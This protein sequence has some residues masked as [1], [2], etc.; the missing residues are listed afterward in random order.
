MTKPT[1]RAVATALRTYHRP[2]R[3]GE[4][5]LESWEQVVERVISHQCW[6]WERA[7]GRKLNERE[8]HELEELRIFNSREIPG[9]RR[10]NSLAGRN[11]A[12]SYQRI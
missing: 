6:L 4:T 10:K 12:Q 9:S 8:W 11:R 7:L 2:I 5:L 3:E 1:A